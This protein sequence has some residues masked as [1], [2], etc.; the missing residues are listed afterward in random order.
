MKSMHDLRQT[1]YLGIYL[2]GDDSLFLS[3]WKIHPPGFINLKILSRLVKKME[4]TISE[5]NPFLS[6]IR[7]QGSGLPS[8]GAL[9]PLR[10]DKNITVTE[11]QRL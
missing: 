8:I 7:L 2:V 6:Y 11:K 3:R 4:R 9:T 5:S 10:M 1:P